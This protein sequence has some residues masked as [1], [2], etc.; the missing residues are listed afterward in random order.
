[1]ARLETETITK[2]VLN[3]RI[4]E[5]LYDAI[6]DKPAEDFWLRLVLETSLH[7]GQDSRITVYLQGSEGEEETVVETQDAEDI[8]DW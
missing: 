2:L 3:K 5:R 8:L 7:D 1:M 6:K 4:V